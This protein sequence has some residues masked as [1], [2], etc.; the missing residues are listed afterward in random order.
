MRLE[1]T[2][3]ITCEGPEVCRQYMYGL[4][5]VELHGC[6]HAVSFATLTYRSLELK[7]DQKDVVFKGVYVCIYGC[8]HACY[9]CMY[10]CM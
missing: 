10:V 3:H 6:C 9:V 2:Y 8:V 4:E 1:L 7:K 5:Y